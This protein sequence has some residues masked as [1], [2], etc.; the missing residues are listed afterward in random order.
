[1]MKEYEKMRREGKTV[2][3]EGPITDSIAIARNSEFIMDKD[4]NR[5]TK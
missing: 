1:M 3:T 4:T 2:N 5:A